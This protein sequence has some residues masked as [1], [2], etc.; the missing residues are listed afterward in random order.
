MSRARFSISCLGDM[1]DLAGRDVQ[2]FTAQS[3]IAQ[4]G[5]RAELAVQSFDRLKGLLIV[6]QAELAVPRVGNQIGVGHQSRPLCRVVQLTE[7]SLVE[8]SLLLRFDALVA[9]LFRQRPDVA[10]LVAQSATSAAVFGTRRTSRSFLPIS[11]N[12]RLAI[13]CM[14]WP[15]NAS[16]IGICLLARFTARHDDQI[17]LVFPVQIVQLIALR[18]PLPMST[19]RTTKCRRMASICA[20]GV[21]AVSYSTRN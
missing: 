16:V 12:F 3:L 21:C 13:G 19:R 15:D 14:T 18:Y 11:R 5:R 7:C 4:R 9:L 2:I 20:R 8:E 17:G 1:L 6:F 10:D